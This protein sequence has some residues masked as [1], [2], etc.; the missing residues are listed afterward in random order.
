KILELDAV[1]EGSCRNR[2]AS[3]VSSPRCGTLSSITK[4]C[5][6]P[7]QPLRQGQS[8]HSST[9]PKV[10]RATRSPA[11]APE[12]LARDLMGNDVIAVTIEIE[13]VSIAGSARFA[14][15]E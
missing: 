8:L 9:E 1:A 10:T 11:A 7:P 3:S 5:V 13:R 6:C 15:V 12:F 2:I 4:R 14:G